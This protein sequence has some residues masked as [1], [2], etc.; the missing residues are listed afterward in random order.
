M[1]LTA[2]L[3]SRLFPLQQLSFQHSLYLDIIKLVSGKEEIKELCL[4]AAVETRQKLLYCRQLNFLP[5][6]ASC[7]HFTNKEEPNFCRQGEK[8]SLKSLVIFFFCLRCTVTR[9][10]RHRLVVL[11]SPNS[12]WLCTVAL[13]Q[14]MSTQ[15][16]KSW[17]YCIFWSI[18]FACLHVT[19][20]QS[21]IFLAT[22]LWAAPGSISPSTAGKYTYFSAEGKRLVRTR[23]ETEMIKSLLKQTSLHHTNIL[24]RAMPLVRQPVWA[25]ITS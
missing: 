6:G 4:I 12:G 13:T 10:Q 24:A 5:G 20:A 23:E 21:T 1:H 9:Q 2:Y 11:L 17:G 19:E 15:G 25:E 16:S 7:E 8:H 3:L 18:M 14:K 22:L